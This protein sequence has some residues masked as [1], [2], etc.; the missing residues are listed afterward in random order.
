MHSCYYYNCNKPSFT[1]G[2]AQSMIRGLSKVEG[3]TDWHATSNQG[4]LLPLWQG[5]RASFCKPCL[6][7]SCPMRLEEIPIF[8]EENCI[9]C[10]RPVFTRA[11]A[12]QAANVFAKMP[13][14]S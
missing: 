8:R 1:V 11:V 12:T 6:D 9:H 7:K 10:R 14:R 5:V 3:L 2:D 4:L 13:G